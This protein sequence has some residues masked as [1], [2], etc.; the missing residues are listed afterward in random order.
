MRSLLKLDIL[1]NKSIP[2]GLRVTLDTFSMLFI[3]W[4][5]CRQLRRRNMTRNRSFSSGPPESLLLQTH[6]LLDEFKLTT[7]SSAAFGAQE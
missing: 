7:K 2:M 6:I 1:N 4:T 5:I 3:K